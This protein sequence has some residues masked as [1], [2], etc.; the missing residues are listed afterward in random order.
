MV[1]NK[2]S[3]LLN[4]LSNNLKADHREHMKKPSNLRNSDK[5]VN[6]ISAATASSKETI[7]KSRERREVRFL[8]KN[9]NL[10]KGL[11]NL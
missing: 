4:L 10:G 9:L 11:Y 7:L 2:N 1:Q 8:S 3:R 5:S 6:S